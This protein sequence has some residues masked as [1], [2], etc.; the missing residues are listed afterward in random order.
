[1]T[2]RKDK[3]R[4]GKGKGKGKEKKWLVQPCKMPIEPFPFEGHC[5]EGT[6][7]H[8]PEVPQWGED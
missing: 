1:M 2:E 7:F 5:S 4:Q 8:A 6:G 3:K